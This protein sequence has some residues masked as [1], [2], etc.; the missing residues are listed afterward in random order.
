MTKTTNPLHIGAP[1][2]PGKDIQ[3]ISF[4]YFQEKNKRIY[5]IVML[6]YDE[7][8]AADLDA[9]VSSIQITK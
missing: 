6:L 3:Q 8:A 7:E 1:D 9:I 5:S 4:K 2:E